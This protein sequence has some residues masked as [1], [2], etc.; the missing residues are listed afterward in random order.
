MAEEKG[1]IP[2][3]SRT[4]EPFTFAVLG[5]IHYKQPEFASAAVAR[6]IGEDARGLRPPLAFV[7]QTGDVAEGG[8]YEKVDG[9]VRFRLAG[10]EAMQDELRFAMKD[11]AGAFQAP[12]FLAIGNHDRHDPGQRA[13][14][15][16]VLPILAR[17]LGTPLE[18]AFYAFRHGNACFVF[19]DYAPADYDAQRDFLR[20]VLTQVR[21]T[22][23]IRH[24]FLF[25]HY[26]LWP[27]AR[28]GFYNPRFTDS[29]LPLVTEF[30]PDAFFCGHTHNTLVCVRKMEGAPV[31]QI[32]GAAHNA[33]A[34]P[35]SLEERRALLFD[36]A[37]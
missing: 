6:A 4:T 17:Q 26:P 19:L 25:G 36:A 24:T 20:G 13:Y 33:G 9:K 31:T 16:E 3:L 32:Q 2:V 12:L 10:Y 28:A 14:N 23:A 22:P 29:V 37:E 5:D 7:C 34:Q 21:D 8:T 1:E 27:V 18:R 15:E 11:M 30:R 35:I